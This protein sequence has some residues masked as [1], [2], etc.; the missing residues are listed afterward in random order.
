MMIIKNSF[1]INDH[2]LNDLYHLING[3]IKLISSCGSP[4]DLESSDKSYD[5]ISIAVVCKNE[6]YNITIRSLFFYSENIDDEVNNLQISFGDENVSNPQDVKYDHLNNKI[7]EIN[8]IKIYGEERVRIWS[9][10]KKRNY[11]GQKTDIEAGDY[12]FNNTIIRFESSDGR[13]VNIFACR[14]VLH[15]DFNKSLNIEND[16]YLVS[17]LKMGEDFAS[18][19]VWTDIQ[20]IKCHYEI[21]EK[22]VTKLIDKEMPSHEQSLPL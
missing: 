15:L 18:A 17:D 8:K 1:Q 2:F 10:V 19:E 13:C 16:F 7:F 6:H 3:E 14:H 5:N 4:V 12:Y 22:G 21:G 20:K 9:E 11:F